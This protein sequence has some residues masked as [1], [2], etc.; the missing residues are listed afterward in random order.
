[1]IDGNCPKCSSNEVYCGPS[2]E[3]EGVSAGGYNSLVEIMVNGKLATLWLNTLICRAC[4]YVEL[5]IANQ[6]DLDLLSGADG[7]EKVE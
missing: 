2:T 3:G 7:W 1:M 6:S 5:R 4:G